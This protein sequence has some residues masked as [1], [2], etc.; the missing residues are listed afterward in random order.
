M[1][2]G[3]E[4]CL[5][6]TQRALFWKG[7]RPRLLKPLGATLGQAGPPRALDHLILGAGKGFSPGRFRGVERI[8]DPGGARPPNRITPPL[9]EHRPLVSTE[10]APQY[11][12]PM[13]YSDADPSEFSLSWAQHISQ[14]FPEGLSQRWVVD[15]IFTT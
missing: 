4:D 1:G 11:F 15:L 13:T 12:V 8:I 9:E 5:W 14:R 7:P 10:Y 3:D 2:K 6:L